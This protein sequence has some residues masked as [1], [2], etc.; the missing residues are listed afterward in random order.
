MQK[1]SRACCT[2]PPVVLRG[3]YNYDPTGTHVTHNGLRTYET[4]P[5]DAKRGIVLIY[6]V[7]GEFIQTI[8]GAD[9]LAT[10]YPAI[11]DTAGEFKVFMPDWFG[12]SPADLAAYPPKTP[13]Q[14][15]YIQEFMGGPADPSRTLPLILPLLST[16]KAS[17]PS[18]QSWAILGFCWGGKL[19]VLLSGEGSEFKASAQTHPS[20]L[21]IKDAREVRIP[22]CVLPSMEEV[23][24]VV[25]PWVEALLKASPKSYSELFEDQVH[26][27]MSSRADFDNLRKF[28]EYL[29]GYRIVRS[30]F[31]EHL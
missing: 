6:D 24:E 12:D 30:F 3:G 8:R 19:A 23:P 1:Q 10:G 27:W 7:F 9:I 11:P 14:F 25:D 15:K 16:L 28:E 18:I 29:R 5:K 21:D 20:L 17:N 31:N 4:G 26:G 22:H 13:A 2:R